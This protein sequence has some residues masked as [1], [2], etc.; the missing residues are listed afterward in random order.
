MTGDRPRVLLLPGIIMPASLRYAPLLEALGDRAQAVTKE[1]E[2]YAGDAVPA[3]YGLDHEIA[4]IDRAARDLGWE[5][6]HLYGHSAGGAVAL[7]YTS[8]HPE[9]V[10]S[11]ALDEPATDFSDE[12]FKELT[13]EWLPLASLPAEEMVQSFVR[14]LMRPDLEPPTPP[15]GP[16]P[17]WMAKRPAGMVAFMEALLRFR[18]D[19]RALAAYRR[20]V[21]YS[22]GDLSNPQWMRMPDRLAAVFPNFSAELYEGASHLTTSHLMAP[23]RVAGRL[24]EIYAVTSS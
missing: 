21:Y 17:E 3:E 11:L 18:L 10:L 13:A 4:G 22:H 8:V 24:L 15:P 9:R 19:A 23:Q 16:V 14:L 20:P 2:I 1:L 12:H 6:F 5:T 7:A